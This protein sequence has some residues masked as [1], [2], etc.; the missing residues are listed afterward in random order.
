[1][2]WSKQ[3][4]LELIFQVFFSKSFCV[5]KAKFLVAKALEKKALLVEQN[6]LEEIALQELNQKVQAQNDLKTIDTLA[7]DTVDLEKKLGLGQKLDQ[8]DQTAMDKSSIGV[9]PTEKDQNINQKLSDQDQQEGHDYLEEYPEE[10]KA[11]IAMLMHQLKVTKKLVKEAFVVVEK[12]EAHLEE[13]DAKIKE[14]S[15]NYRFI[16]ISQAELTV[17]R[18]SVFEL[19]YEKTLPDKVVFA[20]AIR[21]CRKFSTPQGANF[22]HAILDSI[23]KSKPIERPVE[24]V[25][26]K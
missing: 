23:Y 22:V 4:F 20:E 13:I 5:E 17:I 18:L 19:M 12:I 9:V 26:C 7:I 1:M 8:T 15:A 24:E 11:L 21:L 16:R 3:K 10:R 25:C 14:H 6:A 2:A